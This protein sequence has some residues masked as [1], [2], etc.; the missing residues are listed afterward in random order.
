MAI[1]SSQFLETTNCKNHKARGDLVVL[2]PRAYSEA[3]PHSNS[4]NASNARRR[5][6]KYLD[7]VDFIPSNV[8]LVAHQGALLYVM[9]QDNEAVIKT[10]YKGKKSDTETC[11]HRKT[12]QSC[13]LI[14]VVRPNQFGP[15]NP[16]H[17]TLTPKTN[18]EDILRPR[19]FHTMMTSE[20][21]LLCSLNIMPFQSYHIESEEDVEK[22]AKRFKWRKTHRQNAKPM[23]NLVSRC[24]ERTPDVLA[25]TASEST[26]GKLL[27]IEHWQQPLS[28]R[29]ERP[30]KTGRLVLDA[31]SSNYSE[32]NAGKNWSSQE[33]K[34]DDID[35]S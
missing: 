12:T 9:S 4:K 14:E 3:T 27:D 6:L 20:D 5:C 7:D 32:W 18:S 33:W 29:N 25:S 26:G 15:Q 1:W 23:M 34:S 16:N 8:K 30:Q 13:S 35:G 17:I 2:E 24:S 21:H 10:Y 11:F 22:N 28:S 31:Y 19:N